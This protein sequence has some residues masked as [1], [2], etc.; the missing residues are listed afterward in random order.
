MLSKYLWLN[1]QE[2]GKRLG[3]SFN[4]KRALIREYL[5]SKI[6]YYLYQKK[7]SHRLS[8]IGGTSLRMLRGLDRFSEDLDFDNLGLTFLQIKKLFKEIEKDL[9]K[10]G[11]ETIFNLKKTNSSGIGDYK[12]PLLLFGLDISRHRD[13]KLQIKI[14]YTTPKRKPATETVPLSRFGLV[15]LVVTNKLEVLLSQ[16]F[17]A[18]IGR[19]DLQ[20]RDFYDAVWLL[21][22][23]IRPD[24]SIFREFSIKKEKELDRKI[25][26][27][28]Q[29][30]VVSH[31]KD[32]KNRLKPF[33]I[34]EI[35]VS[36]LDIFSKI[37][38]SKM[39]KK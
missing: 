19:K 15:Q 2:E 28:Y 10:E 22:Q 32:F 34:D 12:F 6:I 8:F 21:S 31:L 37:V 3:V 25:L 14:N 36:Y 20:P 29:R 39:K 5:Q 35:K 16:K 13:E 1:I 27:I 4:K 17:K 33:L 26:G 23:N 9:K 30:R 18:I 11:I 7:D 38:E 24:F